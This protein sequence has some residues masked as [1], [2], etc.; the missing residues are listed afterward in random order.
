ML[1]PRAGSG[2][3][4]FIPCYTPKHQPITEGSQGKLKAGSETA[5]E[6]AHWPAL[7]LFQLA[8]FYRPVA[9]IR[10]MLLT[11]GWTLQ[12]WLLIRAVPHRYSYR[13]IWSRQC[14]NWDSNFPGD[15]RLCQINNKLISI[16]RVCLGVCKCTVCVCLGMCMCTVCVQAPKKLN[17]SSL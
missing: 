6:H 1:W 10:M 14:L 17:P 13:P 15:S 16:T 8:L 5:E 9:C 3:K 4:G 12:N 11:M 2:R 7:W